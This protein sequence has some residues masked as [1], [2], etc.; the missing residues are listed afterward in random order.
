MR[1]RASHKEFAMTPE[2][3]TSAR[4]YGWMLGGKD[5][6]DVDRGLVLAVLQGFPECVDIARQNR[7]FL[8]RVV[9]HLVTEAGVSQFLDLGCGLPTE[10][11]VHEVAQRFDPAARVVYVDIDPTVLAH[12]RALLLDR[13][14]AVITADMREPEKIAFHP[15]VQRLI[16]FTEPVA[17]LFLSVGH[18]LKDVDNVGAGARHALRHIIDAVAAPGS[19]VAFSQVVSDDVRRGTEY[20]QWLDGAGV[21]WQHRSPADVD[22]LFEGLDPVDPGLVNVLDWRP[23]PNQPP[24]EPIPDPLRRYEGATRSQSVVYEYGG[25]LRKP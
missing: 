18:H 19:Y 25:L 14:T 1:S 11:N 20:A 21:P 9:R 15:R 17:V 2:Q 13:T 22:A 12:A 5:N 24:L 23:D 3:A 6:Y 16:D 4:A 10:N 7:Q 8:Y